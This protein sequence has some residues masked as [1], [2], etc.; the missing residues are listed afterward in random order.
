MTKDKIYLDE[1]NKAVGFGIEKE[2]NLSEKIVETIIL[3]EPIQE[4]PDVIYVKDVKEF[5]KDLLKCC[6]RN[7]GF[8]TEL[9]IKAGA[10]KELID[11][12]SPHIKVTELGDQARED[13]EPDTSE[14]LGGKIVRKT[15]SG[16]RVSDASDDVCECGHTKGNHSAFKNHCR[17][18]GCSCT[19]FKQKTK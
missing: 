4:I 2:F 7:E 5:I 12:H 16:S 18:R 3:T 17:R 11:N 6:K 15:S 19:K 14:A 8:A 1:K 10:G 13:K 9:E